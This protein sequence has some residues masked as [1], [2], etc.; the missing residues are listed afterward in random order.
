MGKVEAAERQVIELGEN[1]DTLLALSLWEREAE[2]K[3]NLVG[4]ISKLT[5]T[6]VPGSFHLETEL[7]KKM[8]VPLPYQH[9]MVLW[10]NIIDNAVKHNRSEG[11][12]R[13]EGRQSEQRWELI[14]SNSTLSSAKVGTQITQRKYRQG[15]AAGCG[16][17][18]AIV[19]EMCQL[20][21][22]KLEVRESSG[23]MTVTV[24]GILE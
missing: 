13:I 17:G 3:C 10:R 7:P 4:V 5:K 12:I 21:K 23:E 11:E 8:I 22:L 1:V 2:A 24:D 9:A 6:I 14:V 19:A 16:I 20:Y 15:E 18:M